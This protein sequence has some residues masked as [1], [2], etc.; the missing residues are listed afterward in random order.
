MVNV[1]VTNDLG[2][3]TFDY[4]GAVTEISVDSRLAKI[5]TGYYLV[6]LAIADL[7]ELNLGSNLAITGN[8]LIDQAISE[9]A[10]LSPGLNISSDTEQPRENSVDVIV[11]CNTKDILR[12][13]P[14]IRDGGAI[15][16][17]CNSNADGRL[18]F[19]TSLHRKGLHIRSIDVKHDVIDR[20]SE[21][22]A[23]LENIF[24]RHQ[25]FGITE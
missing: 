12:L 2:N 10:S 5:E 18:N 11:G 4:G 6:G 21:L 20:L 13:L 8:H 25:G 17:T 19:Y 9:L 23:R 1:N 14:A 7:A 22:M 16:L 3:L 24:S 15:V